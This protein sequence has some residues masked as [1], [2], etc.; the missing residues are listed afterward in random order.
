MKKFLLYTFGALLLLSSCEKAFIDDNPANDPLSNFDVMWKTVDEKYTFFIPKGINWDSIRNVYRPMVTN[1]MNEQELFDVLAA[2]LYTLED[3]HVNLRSPFNLSRN[4]EWY[5]DYPDNFI[6][7]VVERNYLG[8]DYKIAGG[9]QYTII[10]SVG[11][12]Y[13]GSFSSGFS[14][15]SLNAV[16]TYFNEATALK[17]VIIDVRNNGGG[18]LNN[19]LVLAQ[20]FATEK[21][22]CMITFEKTGPAHDD[23][24]NGLSYSLKPSGEVNYSGPVVLLT[25]R[26]CYSATNTFAAL[27]SNYPHVTIVGAPTGGGGGIPIDNELPNGWTYRFSA[28]TSLLPDNFNIEFGVPVDSAVNNN[29]TINA[30]GYD[31]ILETGL[32][33][34]KAK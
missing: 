21:R 34:L 25:N 13:Y 6:E 8:S 30:G 33:I 4:W 24:G 5:L 1:D 14:L 29:P 22:E 26:R 23:F 2:M 31:Q 17:G 15:A 11:Y 32:A 16:I 9:L 19:A 27:L 3:G 20:R 7:E 28:T 18:S 12:I 10:D